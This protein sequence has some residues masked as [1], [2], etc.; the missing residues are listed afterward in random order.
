MIILSQSVLDAQQKALDA[1]VRMEMLK[2]QAY[3]DSVTGMNTGLTQPYFLVTLHEGEWWV[4]QSSY[5]WPPIPHVGPFMT[6][7]GAEDALEA[8]VLTE[9]LVR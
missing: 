1:F 9:R 6:R 2:I 8:Q 3:M 7:F 4:M 5:G